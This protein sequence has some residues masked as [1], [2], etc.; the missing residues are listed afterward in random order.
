MSQ[1]QW[2]VYVVDQRSAAIPPPP[3]DQPERRVLS[4]EEQRQALI[5]ILDVVIE[6]EKKADKPSLAESMERAGIQWRGNIAPVPGHPNL[7]YVKDAAGNVTFDPI[8]ADEYEVTLLEI[9]LRS[10][11]WSAEQIQR[12]VEYFRSTLPG[13][14][15]KEEAER[16]LD[17][18]RRQRVEEIGR[19]IGVA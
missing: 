13:N 9:D 11:Q 4:A 14:A 2:G 7:I 19:E 17:E 1:P 12:A 8:D 5:E 10:R 15:W 6:H 18:F 16:K 3:V